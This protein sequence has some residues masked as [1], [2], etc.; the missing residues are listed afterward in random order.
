MTPAEIVKWTEDILRDPAR[1]ESLS[2]EDA[3]E[4]L[5][6][7]R[8][9]I[10]F[11]D[12]R[13][14]VLNDPVIADV[15]YDQLFALLKILES[16]YPGL[17][18][19][20]SPTQRVASGLV[21]EFPEV[22]HYTPMLSL[23]NTYN[24][25][26]LL[27]FDRRVRERLGVEQVSYCVEVKL[28]GASTALVYENDVLV[29][30]A[31]RGDG[32]TGEEVT[33]SIRTIRSVP[34]RAPFSR[35]GVTRIEIR[36]EVLLFRD[37]FDRLNRERESSGLPLFANPR[38]AAAGTLRLQDPEEVARRGLEGFW[39][40][41][42]YTEGTKITEIAS[43]Q[44]QVLQFLKE[45]GFRVEPHAVEVPSIE[46]VVQ[47]CE[48]MEEKMRRLAYEADGLVV[49]VNRL[50]WHEVLGATLHHPRYAVAYK[51]QANNAVT[52]IVDIVVQVGRTGTLTPTAL[53]EPVGIGGV[54]VSRVTLFNEDE[55]RRKDIRIGDAVLVERAG[56]VI[57]HIV[58]VIPEMRTGNERVFEFPKRCPSCG[59]PVF[60]DPGEVA[61]RCENARCPAQI[62]E[63]ILHFAS[64]NAMNIEGL[65]EANVSLFVDLE[66][67]KD[68]ADLYTLDFEA[69]A[70]LERWGEK[71][72]QNLRDAIE[73]S[74]TAELWRVIHG[75]GIRYV[76]EKAARVLAENIPSI[77]DLGRMSEAELT[78]IP[79]FGPERARSVVE[80]FQVSDNLEVL[81]KLERA[82]VPLAHEKPIEAREAGPLTGKTFVFTGELGRWTRQKAAAIVESLGGKVSGSVSGKTSFVVVGE[83]PGSKARKATELGVPTLTEEEFARLIQDCGYT[84]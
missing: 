52:R 3:A 65:G 75:L 10:R 42:S 72:A 22:R 30:G 4:F 9:I 15:Q 45:M 16:R 64:R 68:V 28:D 66:W 79:G 78:A 48:T 47:M 46:G 24:R 25:E 5:P 71:S 44:Y 54:T 37:Q 19:P 70:G 58:K 34:L 31:T 80:F 57:P 36:G 43:T 2:E 1:W 84:E 29:R 50:E 39:Y 67:V 27:E 33:H 26:E 83:N 11:H 63:R 6:R 56:D 17:V 40:A 12:H 32:V 51:F 69:L 59:A 55:I 14:Y 35:Y 77:W 18:T 60:R 49:K 20:D 53:L 61:W 73:K 82:G 38:N 23:D 8:E 62:K 81:K 76:G 74:K 41:V 13:Y 7:L 21:K